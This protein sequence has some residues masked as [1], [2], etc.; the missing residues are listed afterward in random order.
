MRNLLTFFGVLGLAFGA[1]AFFGAKTVMHEIVGMLGFLIATVGLGA[2]GIMR[3][4][5]RSRAVAQTQADIASSAS[6]DARA[7]RILLEQHATAIARA[8]EDMQTI[9]L[10][11]AVVT[12]NELLPVAR[13]RDRVPT[14]PGAG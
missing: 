5:E 6:A 4:I 1:Y 11:Q 12:E 9:A 10:H 13:A 7:G 8:L 3:E 2:T 14:D